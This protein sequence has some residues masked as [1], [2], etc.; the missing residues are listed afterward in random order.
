MG[1]GQRSLRSHSGPWL[2]APPPP[3][4]AQRVVFEDPD[5]AA[6]VDNLVCLHCGGGDD[7]DELLLCDGGQG[8]GCAGQAGAVAM[9][10]TARRHAGHGSCRAVLHGRGQDH[11]QLLLLCG[12]GKGTGSR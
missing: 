7:E 12:G 6:W 10:Y 5:F 9:R 4:R 11:G 3:C 8:G 2:P 1:L